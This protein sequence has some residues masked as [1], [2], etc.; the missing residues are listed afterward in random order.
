[1]PAPAAIPY[2]P[3]F[4][5]WRPGVDGRV[6]SAKGPGGIEVQ[7]RV[8]SDPAHTWR[9]VEITEDDACLLAAS[10][11]QRAGRTK[12]SQRVLRKLSDT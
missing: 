3:V 1:M 8:A 11:L 5:D 4:H 2:P 6:A 10:L 12:L 9:S 7:M